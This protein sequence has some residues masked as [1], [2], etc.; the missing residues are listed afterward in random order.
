MRSR[1][2]RGSISAEFAVALPTVV[3]VLLLVLSLGLHG[4]AQ[5]TLETGARAAARELARGEDPASA[6][7]AARR[8]AGE[9]VSFR[10]SQ[11]QGYV[12]VTLLR[13]VRVLGWVEV[14]MT[15]DAAATARVEELP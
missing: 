9:E 12:T 4:A 5:V 15:Q 6:E 8:V 13:P 11:E 14:A 3:L 1:S 10:L 7:A 2:E